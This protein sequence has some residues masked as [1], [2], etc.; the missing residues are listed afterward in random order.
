VNTINLTGLQS[1][2]DR[3]STGGTQS[4]TTTSTISARAR[5]KSVPGGDIDQLEVGFCFACLF[6]RL[7]TEMKTGNLGEV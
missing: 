1:S 2:S 7:T 5:V 4:K 6:D 3:D